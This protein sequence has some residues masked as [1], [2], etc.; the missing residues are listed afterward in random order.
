[1]A[2]GVAPNVHDSEKQFQ[3]QDPNERQIHLVLDARF[4]HTRL[5]TILLKGITRAQP[6][7]I[8]FKTDDTGKENNG[9]HWYHRAR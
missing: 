4:G 6:S 8:Y 3:D 9:E 1:M 5:F 2:K 7:L